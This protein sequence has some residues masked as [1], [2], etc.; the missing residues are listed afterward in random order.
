MD[1]GLLVNGGPGIRAGGNIWLLSSFFRYE[2]A[3]TN[4]NCPEQGVDMQNTLRWI[5][6]TVL[7]KIVKAAAPMN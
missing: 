2:S 6:M 3:R 7:K 1:N 4:F 5:W